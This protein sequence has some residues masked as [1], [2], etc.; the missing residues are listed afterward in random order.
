M[1]HKLKIL[2]EYFMQLALN[3]KKF[4]LRKD[5][6]NYKEGDTLM[7][8]EWNGKGYTGSYATR[9]ITHILRDCPE[10]GLKKGYVILSIE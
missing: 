4:E 3:K 7:L 9:I 6:R 10:Y 5:D 2:P 1:Q 8:K